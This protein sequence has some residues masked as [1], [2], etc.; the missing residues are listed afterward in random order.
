MNNKVVEKKERRRIIIDFEVLSNAG[1]WMCCMKDFKTGNEHTII[2]DRKELLRVFNKNKDSVWVGYNIKGYDQWIMKSIIAGIDPCMVSSR[3]INDNMNGWQVHPSLNKIKLFIFELSDSYRSL[4][5]LELFMGEDIR[6]STVPFDLKRYPTESEIK[7]LTT[8][9]LHDVKMTYKVFVETYHKYEAQLGLIEYFN[10]DP[11]MF[12]KTEAQLSSH[13]LG[14]SKPSKDRCDTFNFDIVNTLKLS[15]YKHVEEWYLKEDNRDFKK[16]LKTTIY[17]VPTDFGWGGLHSA[18]KKYKAEEFIV[19]S[20]V[21]SFYPAIMIEYNLLSRNVE[22]PSKF[23]EIRDTR[24]NFKRENNKIEKSLK[25]ILNSTFGASKDVNN[26]LYDPKQGNAVCVNGQ[27]LLLDLIEKVELEFGDNAVFIQGN[28]DGVMFKFNSQKDVDKYI[29]ICNEWSTRTRMELEHD[30]IKRIIQEDVNNYIFVQNNGKVKSKGAYVKKLSL[31]DNDLP[32][33]NHALVEYMLNNTPI[34][35]T[36]NKSNN[37]IDF[38]KCV[39]IT[40]KYSHALHGTERLDLKVLRVFAS[41]SATDSSIMKVKTGENPENIGNTPERAFIDNDNI[42]NKG[43]PEKLDRQWYINLAQKR[44]DDFM[45][46][47]TYNLFD[48]LEG[49]S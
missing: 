33:V 34:E 24:I 48:W 26:E 11:S 42:I 17:G 8:Y 13:I 36:I 1:F 10:L 9:C 41:K 7:E 18:R 14:A 28:T 45:P 38:Q 23:K 46:I 39:K 31:L 27:L 6:E 40:G 16:S 49:L 35:E 21:S 25:I 29:E 44:L 4:K 3:I 37:L 47:S 20:D 22:N 12:N 15:K 19:N 2:N 43:I 30:F 5:E 32:I